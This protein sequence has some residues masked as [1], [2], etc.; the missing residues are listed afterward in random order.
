MGYIGNQ[1]L[2]VDAILTNAG[3]RKLADDPTGF[4]I[5][6]FALSDDEIDYRLWNENHSLGSDYYGVAISNLPILE[7]IPRESDMLKYKLITMTKSTTYIP[8]LNVGSTSIPLEAGGWADIAPYVTNSA[9][10]NSI[11]GYTA[12][13]SD[14]SV[15][16]LEVLSSAGNAKAVNVGGSNSTESHT[17][18]HVGKTFRVTGR[19]LLTAKTCKLTIVGNE[20]GGFAQITITVS[21]DTTIGTTPP[22]GT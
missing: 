18:T 6:K 14:S 1:T 7:A 10:A 12:T 9:N 2:T 8:S 11:L 22:L 15:C 16:E 5:T 19:K 4:K 20:T 3:R 21:A 13:L 17:I